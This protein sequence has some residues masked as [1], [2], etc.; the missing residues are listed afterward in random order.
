MGLDLAADL[1]AE[2]SKAGLEEG[3]LEA[4]F[5]VGFARLEIEKLSEAAF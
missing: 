2:Q 4:D 5:E 1:E 3:H